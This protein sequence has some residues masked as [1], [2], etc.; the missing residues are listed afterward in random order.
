[1]ETGLQTSCR[2][3]KCGRSTAAPSAYLACDA[4]PKGYRATISYH[5]MVFDPSRF[6]HG[7]THE[8]RI[9]IHRAVSEV[10]LGIATPDANLPVVHPPAGATLGLPCILKQPDNPN[11][12][13]GNEDQVLGDALY[14][15]VMGVFARRI[16]ERRRESAA[17]GG[18]P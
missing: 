13:A 3:S 8:Y 7:S 18:V 15:E 14:R 5:V 12:D 16:V 4:L 2:S 9:S 17:A 6:S 1:M 10:L 11:I